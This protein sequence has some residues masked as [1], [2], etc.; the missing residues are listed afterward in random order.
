MHKYSTLDNVIRYIY[1]ETDNK[2]N[3]QIEFLLKS[4]S[5]INK[6][7]CKLRETCNYL[8]CLKMSPCNSLIKDIL[9]YSAN[10]NKFDALN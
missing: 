1:K 6:E 4:D 10:L 8:N 7:C 5:E 9:N 3:K 2:E